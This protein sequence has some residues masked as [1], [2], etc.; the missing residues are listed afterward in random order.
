MFVHIRLGTNTIDN[1]FPL[2]GGC[3][4]V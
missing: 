3:L 4:R 1:G 2:L